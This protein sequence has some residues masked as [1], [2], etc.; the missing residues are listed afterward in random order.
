MKLT[1]A[2]LLRKILRVLE[3]LGRSPM[4]RIDAR[5]WVK[6]FKRVK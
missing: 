4:A 3:G 6:W 1:K 5:E 2:Q